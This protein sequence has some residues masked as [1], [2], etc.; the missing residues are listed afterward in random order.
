MCGLKDELVN[1]PIEATIFATMK[2]LYKQELEYL[3]IEPANCGFRCKLHMFNT[4]PFLEKRHYFKVA[5][6]VA[7]VQAGLPMLDQGNCK[8]LHYKS[9]DEGLNAFA[10]AYQKHADCTA[11]ER[12]VLEAF[13]KSKST[14]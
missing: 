10:Y 2:S 8:T 3:G 13:L 14:K 1:M 9:S 12:K 11:P 6:S 5:A 4:M 7:T